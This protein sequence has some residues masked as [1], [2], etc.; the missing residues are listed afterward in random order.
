MIKKNISIIVAIDNN[1]GIGKDNKLLTYISADLKHFKAITTGNVIIMG[2]NTWFSLPNKPLPNRTNIVITS[3]KD[4]KLFEGA[5]IAPS[6]ENAIE[7]CP[8]NEECFVIGGAKIYEQF[9][10]FANKL[11]LT[12]IDKEFNADTFFPKINT[13][14]WIKVKELEI[15]N[16]KQANVK[17]SFIELERI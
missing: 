9:L 5:I 16:D 11:Y 8:E 1:N 6:I 13:F 17:Y 7:K 3:K 15:K 12:K 2:S 14:D 4:S 10:P